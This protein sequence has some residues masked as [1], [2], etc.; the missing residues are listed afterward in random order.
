MSRR[1]NKQNKKIFNQKVAEKKRNWQLFKEDVHINIQNTTF[2]NKVIAFSKL[3]L[4]VFIMIGV[5]IIMF[6]VFKNTLFDKDYL[7][8]LPKRLQS[9]KYIAFLP[10][11]LL[12]IMQI[13]ICILPGQPIQFAT[14]YIYGIWIGYLISIVGAVIGSII[15]YYLANFLGSESLHLL[16]GEKRVKDYIK[17]LNSRRAYT[18]IFFIYLIPGIP[19]DM[20]SYVAGISN[21][22]IKPFLLS[23]TLGRTPGL[24]ESLLFG[25]FWAKKNYLG[26]FIVT[27]VTLGILWICYKK[28]ES[29]MNFLASYEDDE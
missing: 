11:I 5:P 2:K 7:L 29:L 15:T 14:S 19:K 17:K 22:K 6:F 8:S 27:I 9:H 26:I 24:F 10:L 13:I 4:L 25:M 18:I 23:S 20:V 28:K 21:I 1:N 3:L 16:F 12:Q